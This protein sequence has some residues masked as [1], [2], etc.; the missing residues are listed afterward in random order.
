MHG[1]ACGGCPTILWVPGYQHFFGTCPP[2][3]LPVLSVTEPL[4]SEL[5]RNGGLASHFRS[6]YRT[7]SVSGRHRIRPYPLTRPTW[8]AKGSMEVEI[9]HWVDGSHTTD[10]SHWRPGPSSW[11]SPHKRIAILPPRCNNN[12][13]QQ[14]SLADQV[15]RRVTHSPSPPPPAE[16]TVELGGLL[17]ATGLST[18]PQLPSPCPSEPTGYQ[19][20]SVAQQQPTTPQPDPGCGQ[21]ART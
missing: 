15:G 20:C 8:Q 14:Q 1:C 13:S 16:T 19:P 9:G 11:S 5:V 10:R 7:G 17:A 4:I 2:T 6:L 12:H 21:P 3:H 18:G